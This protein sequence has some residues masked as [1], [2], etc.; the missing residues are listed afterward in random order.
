MSSEVR[1]WVTFVAVLVV[2]GAGIALTLTGGHD[3]P[4]THETLTVPT[5]GPDE[6]VTVDRDNQLEVDEL[7][8]DRESKPGTFT[9]PAV[10]EPLDLHEDTRDETPAGI[11]KDQVQAGREKAERTEAPK[12]D[13]PQEPAGAQAYDCRSRPV[14]N[15]SA[16]SGRRYGV[17]LHFTVS[18][19][20]SLDAIY[21]LFNRRSFGA[22]SNIGFEL[23]NLRCQIWV[24]YDRKAWAQGAFN[25]AYISIEIISNDRSR[26]SWLATP[27]LKY[28]VLAALVRDLLKRT[29]AP[30]KLVDPVGC[31]PKAGVVDHDRLECG[32]SHW[33]VGPGFPWDVFMRQV[34]QGVAGKVTN[35]LTKVERAV[36]N[37]RCWHRA[38][39]L[40]GKSP[41][42]NLKWARH[43][44]RR[45]GKLRAN[46]RQL[47]LT[48]KHQRKL[49]H[50][51][52][53]GYATGKACR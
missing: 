26:A 7:R 46:L 3:E 4:P 39:H 21:G 5:P 52:L 45:I 12:L 29:G 13:D 24:G 6:K 9:A 38:Q 19:P 23:F 16:L 51:V 53:G 31:T 41:A 47:G 49:R 11:T 36:V 2:I 20:G 33:D 14:V 8:E 40:A 17:A 15:Q 48:T 32:N 22:S 50:R 1:K 30:A 43:Y 18:Q 37:K 10:K 44:I 28:G 27:A 42:A 35:V 34:R 25:S